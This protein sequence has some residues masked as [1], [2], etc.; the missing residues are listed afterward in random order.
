MLYGGWDLSNLLQYYIDMDSPWGRLSNTVCR[1]TT[2]TNFFGWHAWWQLSRASRRWYCIIH[3]HVETTKTLGVQKVKQNSKIRKCHLK[4]V[5]QI[6]FNIQITR[7]KRLEVRCHRDWRVN[8]ELY[9]RF[10]KV[11]N[12]TKLATVARI[13][14]KCSEIISRFKVYQFVVKS[15]DTDNS[16][17]KL[18]K[19]RPKSTEN[20]RKS[21][22][23]SENR[24][25]LT[26]I[27]KNRA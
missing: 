18:E 1:P 14:K 12:K 8:I 15:L 21:A 10:I 23:I 26:K 20:R 17:Y 13:Q 16:K 3:L 6:D 11:R 27:D 4:Q 2:W 5:R 24:Q 9:H 7:H 25:K 19:N 22:K